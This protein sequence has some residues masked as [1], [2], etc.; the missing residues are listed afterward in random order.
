MIATDEPD[1]VVSL[2]ITTCPSSTLVERPVTDSGSQRR[3]EDLLELCGA[4]DHAVELAPNVALT[5]DLSIV[6]VLA[7]PPSTV[8]SKS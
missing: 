7:V 8:M 5:S 2:V 4:P 3:V 1:P 6:T